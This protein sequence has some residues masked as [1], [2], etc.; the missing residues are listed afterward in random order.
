M[1]VH[2]RRRP[3]VTTDRI[4]ALPAAQSPAQI[5]CHRCALE[6]YWH[7]SYPQIAVLGQHQLLLRLLIG[8]GLHRFDVLHRRRC[9]G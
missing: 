8:P 4:S 2:R 3:D 5:D 7:M 1:K 6:R 9:T